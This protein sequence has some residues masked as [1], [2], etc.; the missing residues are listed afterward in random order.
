MT[1]LLYLCL[2]AI[3]AVDAE[4]PFRP[5]DLARKPIKVPNVTVHRLTDGSA[6]VNGR[7]VRRVELPPLGEDEETVVVKAGAVTLRNRTQELLR[8]DISVRVYNGY[9]VWAGTLRVR[10]ALD[11]V[12]PGRSAAAEEYGSLFRPSAILKNCGLALPADFDVPAYVTVQDES[13]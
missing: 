4:S 11:T 10:W 12:G 7:L 5:V 9:G 1:T 3:L 8:P 6:E 13:K 2:G